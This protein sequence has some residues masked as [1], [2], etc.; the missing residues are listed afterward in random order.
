MINWNWTI[1]TN[2]DISEQI[3][4]Y[5]LFSPLI[6]AVY[7]VWNISIECGRGQFYRG[8]PY[9]WVAR[10]S[11]ALN[12]TCDS[13]TDES[14]FHVSEARN[15][16]YAMTHGMGRLR[17]R[18]GGFMHNEKNS[19]YDKLGRIQAESRFCFQDKAEHDSYL[20]WETAYIH[21]RVSPYDLSVEMTGLYQRDPLPQTRRGLGR[22]EGH[23]QL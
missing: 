22:D 1:T 15:E 8:I 19:R 3:S 14:S 16:P 21:P 10:W 7:F 2:L 17:V 12:I 18:H 20:R 9:S 6:F 5:I 11:F 23:L 13:K 4:W